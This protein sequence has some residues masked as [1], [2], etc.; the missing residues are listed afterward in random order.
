MPQPTTTATLGDIWGERVAARRTEIGLKQAQLAELCDVTQQ[1]ISKIES[2]AM[3]PR[4][5]LKLVIAA[6]L[7][8]T[9]DALF[10][11]PKGIRP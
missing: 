9:P 5:S 2:G 7:G 11:W 10:A 3:V 6:K 1:T 4:D 8:T